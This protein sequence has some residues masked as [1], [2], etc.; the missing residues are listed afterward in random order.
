VRFL[1]GTLKRRALLP[2]FILQLSC[3]FTF[4]FQLYR[5]CLRLIRHVAPGQVSPKSLALRR[6]VRSEFEKYRGESDVAT[7]E[8]AKLNAVRAL[9]NY[10]LAT[11]APKDPRAKQAI[12]DFHGRSVQAAKEHN[13]R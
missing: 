9:S 2:S 4:S 3:T 10:M 12:K 1:V 13:V 11:A 6:T 7:I 8:N 5:D